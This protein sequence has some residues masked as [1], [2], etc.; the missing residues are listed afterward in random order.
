MTELMQYQGKRTVVTGAASG[1]GRAT[2]A[3][4]R[5]LGA[6]VIAL[7]IKPPTDAVE[8]YLETDL[9]DEASIDAALERI[10][11]PVDG[12]FYCAGLPQKF[13][14]PLDL[15]LVNFV[16]ARHLIRGLMPK[17]PSGSAIACVSSIAGLGWPADLPTWLE[18]VGTPDFASAKSWCEDPAH[19]E[20]IDDGYSSS[21]AAMIVYVMQ[22]ASEAISSGLRI[23]AISPGS[24]NTPLMPRFIEIAGQAAIDA[25]KSVA[26]RLA[27][28]EEMAGPL[29]FLNSPLASYINGANLV[30]DGGFSAVWTVSGN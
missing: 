9:R 1:M 23:N 10:E 13:F 29:A 3:L 22:S 8:A 28:S 6:K 16:G 5:E 24:T 12:L 14:P 15:M 20:L 11:A 18:L 25:V 2:S 4:L 17:M 27:E 21:K 26:G 7:D 30:I 19:S